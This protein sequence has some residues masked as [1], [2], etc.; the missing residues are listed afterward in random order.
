MSIDPFKY[1]RANPAPFGYVCSNCPAHGVKLWR[2]YPNSVLAEHQ[3]LLCAACAAPGIDVDDD[4]RRD[5]DG[6][7][8]TWTDQLDHAE[9]GSMVPAVPTEDGETFWGYTSV[10]EDGVRWWRALP[11]KAKP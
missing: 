1:L 3:V 2:L 11:T 9:H 5:D 4:G 6:G 10:P 7:R 8:E